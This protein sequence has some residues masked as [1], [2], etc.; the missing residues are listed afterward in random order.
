MAQSLDPPIPTTSVCGAQITTHVVGHLITR[1]EVEAGKQGGSLSAEDIRACAQRFLKDELPHFTA[2]FQRSYDDCSHR[3]EETHWSGLRKQPLERILAKKFAQLLPARK[4][5][6]GQLGIVSRRVLPGFNLAITKMIGP[7]LYDQCQHKA[8]TI[9]ERHATAQGGYDWK[10]VYADPQCQTL[11]NDVMVVVAHYFSD[12]DRR[13]NW[14]MDLVNSNL[15]PAKPGDD[16]HAN[17]QLTN[18]SFAEMM[19]ALFADLTRLQE[20]QPDK[21]MARYGEYT[22][23]SLTVFLDR[24]RIET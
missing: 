24:L 16:L 3:R 17:W 5:D 22:R 4:G 14:F 23:H 7:M 12:F 18:H 1:L 15:A 10:A 13:R 2:A 21:L 9:L 20:N 19:R 6:D 8:A 11:T